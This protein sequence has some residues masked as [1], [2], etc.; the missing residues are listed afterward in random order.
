[1]EWLPISEAPK[2]GT[3]VIAFRPT[4][5]PHIEGMHCIDGAWDWSYDGDGPAEFSVQPTHFMPLP[6]PPK[7]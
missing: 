7:G 1:M 6:P 3:T 2:D 4:S 5:P